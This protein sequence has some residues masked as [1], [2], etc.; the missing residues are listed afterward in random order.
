MILKKLQVEGTQRHQAPGGG[1]WAT[2]TALLVVPRPALPGYLPTPRH[3]SM[4]ASGRDPEEALKTE[5]PH[6]GL[7]PPSRLVSSQ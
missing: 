3:H 2:V 4:G 1:C 6:G 7:G 5:W